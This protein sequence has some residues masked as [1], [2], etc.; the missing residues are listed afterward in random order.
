MSV[1]AAKAAKIPICICGEAP[2]LSIIESLIKTG[3]RDFSIS[4]RNIQKFVGYLEDV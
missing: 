1:K 4:P 2:H 3:L